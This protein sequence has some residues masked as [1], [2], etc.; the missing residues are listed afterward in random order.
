MVGFAPKVKT[1]TID[2]AP[3]GGEGMLTIRGTTGNIAEKTMMYS[4]KLRKEGIDDETLLNLMLS[5]FT[6]KLC[7]ADAPFE[8][9]DDTVGEFPTALIVKIMEV[10]GVLDTDH[11]LE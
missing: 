5:K 10:I 3:Y 4:Q 6:C 8:I 11:P 7:I 9:T 2:L 1:Q